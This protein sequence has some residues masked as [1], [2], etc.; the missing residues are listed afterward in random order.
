MVLS[1]WNR[2][3][4]F[5]PDDNLAIGSGGLLFL[6]ERGLDAKVEQT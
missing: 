2:L 4:R 1:E 6:P 5:I 3:P